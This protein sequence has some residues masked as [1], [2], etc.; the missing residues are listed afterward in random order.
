[1]VHEVVGEKAVRGL[2][3]PTL[4]APSKKT[5]AAG[6]TDLQLKRGQSPPTALS[7]T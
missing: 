3:G 7:G 4:P 6:A 1:M 2:S 5:A